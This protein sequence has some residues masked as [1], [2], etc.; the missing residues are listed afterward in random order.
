[1]KLL[2]VLVTLAACADPAP[3]TAVIEQHAENDVCNAPFYTP[4]Y[5]LQN[6]NCGAAC[7]PYLGYC[8]EY[9]QSDYNHCYY[10]LGSSPCGTDGYIQPLDCDQYCYPDYAKKC[11][12]GAAASPATQDGP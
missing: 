1:M 9:S 3:S 12:Q 7:Y 4:C 10:G 8:P 6:P 2:A 5:P 11:L